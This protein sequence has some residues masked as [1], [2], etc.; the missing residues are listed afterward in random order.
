MPHQTS[1]ICNECAEKQYQEALKVACPFHSCLAPIGQRCNG[2]V[3]PQYPHTARAS[4]AS[5][6]HT[7]CMVKFC[8]TMF[9]GTEQTEVK[10]D[11]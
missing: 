9:L 11:T 5:V 10:C 8:T 3:F 2:I 1:C 6:V 7:D 4:R